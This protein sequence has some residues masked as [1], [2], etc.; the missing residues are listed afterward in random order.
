M[1]RQVP[2]NVRAGK[3]VALALCL[4]YACMAVARAE[5]NTSNLITSLVNNSGTNYFVGYSGTNNSLAISGGGI[6]SN[7][8][9]GYIGNTVSAS[10]NWVVITDSGSLWYN[11]AMLLVGYY[12]SGNTL[13]IANSS[14]VF[15]WSGEIGC[16]SGA[17]TTP[18]P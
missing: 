2:T 18:L 13:T 9:Y 4:V 5:D 17:N 1:S 11:N 3:A 8:N 6:L 15:S 14:T 7:V 16:W 10:N 12:G